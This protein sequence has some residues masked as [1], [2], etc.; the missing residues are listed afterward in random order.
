[1]R[2]HGSILLFGGVISCTAC[3]Q[4][5]VEVQA[6]ADARAFAEIPAKDWPLFRGDPALT[7]IAE[8]GL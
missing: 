1:M 4:E 2:V 3:V 5:V 6:F 7:G 8:P